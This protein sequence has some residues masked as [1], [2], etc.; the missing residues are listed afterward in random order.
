MALLSV[1]NLTKTLNERVLLDAVSLRIAPGERV[2]LVGANGGGKSTL[3]RI[4]AGVETFDGGTRSMRRGLRLG[5][6]EQEPE[7]DS[8]LDVRGAV[9]AGLPERAAVLARIDAVHEE[10]ARAPGALGAG[11]E[12]LLARQARLEAELETLGGHDVEHRIEATVQ[13]LGLPDPDAPCAS[14]SGGER[15]RVALARLLIGR[16]E[17]LLLDEPTNHLDAFVTDWLEDWFLE[18]RTPLL[19]VTHDRYFL[20]RVVDWSTGSSSSSGASCSPTRGATASTSRRAPRG[21]GASGGRRTRAPCSCGARPPGCGAG[22]RRARPR[23]RRASTATRTSSTRRRPGPR[24]SSS[25]R[26][27]RA[28]GWG[29]ASCGWRA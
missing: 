7:L 1:E 13:A 17:L 21:S 4:L 23:P 9:R 24:A 28:R 18:T 12:R 20:D 3:L 15:R 11:L 2:G 27:R 19:L 22:R 5:H 14:L 8:A 10:L 6:L 25:S 26:S 29:R 16:P